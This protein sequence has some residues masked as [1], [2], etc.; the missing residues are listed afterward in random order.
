MPPNNGAAVR[1]A[2][3]TI[4][5]DNSDRQELSDGLLGLTIVENTAGLYR[6]EAMFGNWGASGGNGSSSGRIGWIYF[7]RRL[8][9]FGKPL[10][11]TYENDLLFDGRILALEALFPETGPRSITALAED[12]FQDLRMTRR[13]RTFVDVT[14]ADVF[15]QIASNHGLTAQV[16]LPAVQHKVLAQVNQSD[17]AFLRERA[18]SVDAELWMEG[19]QLHA[20]KHTSRGGQPIAL[21]YRQDLREFSVIADLAGQRTSVTASGWDVAGKQAIT[22]EA[23]ESVIRGELNGDVSGVSILQT[24]LGARKEHLS[25]TVPL[26]TPDAQNAA[27][28]FFKLGARRFVIGRGVASVQSAMHA[29]TFVQLSELGPLFSGKYYVTEVRHVFDRTGLRTEFAAERPG[30]GRV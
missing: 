24:A 3:P 1:S 25:H 19:S 13:T 6:C 8:L 16:D 5:V 23:G 10:K 12:R 30:L 27:E 20:A 7:D 15:R 29:G 14:D 4:N 18:R 17:L 11:V 21:V 26:T 9:D 2:R 22:H 28:A